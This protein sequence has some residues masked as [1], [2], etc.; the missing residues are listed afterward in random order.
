MK[1]L[2]KILQ[3][4][5]GRVWNVCELNGILTDAQYEFLKSLFVTPKRFFLNAE[6]GAIEK[7][8]D[9]LEFANFDDE[10]MAGCDFEGVHW[11]CNSVYSDG[12]AEMTLDGW[13]WFLVRVKS[14]DYKMRIAQA[15]MLIRKHEKQL[16]MIQMRVKRI[17]NII[18]D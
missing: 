3:Y 12:T 7:R 4:H 17:E 14:P 11:N 9:E 18:N 15:K 6:T 2:E 10:W 8:I 13:N 16:R 1:N 5:E